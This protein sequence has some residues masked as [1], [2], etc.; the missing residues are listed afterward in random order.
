M[1]VAAIIV[2]G[3]ALYELYE[4]YW[5]NGSDSGAKGKGQDPG[6]APRS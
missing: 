2:I 1:F 3:F 5:K 6:D 4:R